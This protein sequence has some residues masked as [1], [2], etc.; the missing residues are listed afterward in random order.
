MPETDSM[1]LDGESP[2]TQ[3]E[4]L[5]LRVLLREDDRAT[6]LR[7]QIRVFTPWLVATVAAAYS[8]GSWIVSHWKAA[9]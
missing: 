5:R 6:W 4:V 7:K 3:A 8:F 2:L 1:P 9:P